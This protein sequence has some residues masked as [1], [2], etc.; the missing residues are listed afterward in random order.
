MLQDERGTHITAGE[1]DGFICQTT[2]KQ[3]GT[4]P[5]TVKQTLFANSYPQFSLGYPELGFSDPN[6]SLRHPNFSLRHP[7]FSLGYPQISL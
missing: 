5:A 2:V 3:T 1:S 6:F 7:Q 4:N